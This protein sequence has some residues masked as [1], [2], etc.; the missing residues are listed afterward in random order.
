MSDVS[1]LRALYRP[2]KVVPEPSLIDLGDALQAQ[3]LRLAEDPTPER[4]Q[5]VI[6]NLDGERRAVIRMSAEAT[7][8]DGAA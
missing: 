8:L 2:D 4:Y 5:A 7:T 1:L 6:A 3:F